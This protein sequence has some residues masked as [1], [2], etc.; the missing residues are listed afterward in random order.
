MSDYSEVLGELRLQRDRIDAAIEAL[1]NLQN[2]GCVKQN[3]K[4]AGTSRGRQADPAI[5]EK[6]VKLLEAGKKPA[7]V[8]EEISCSESKVYAVKKKR[9]L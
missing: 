1:E 3:P 6:I 7:A 9:N 8:A 4:A 5:E 2:S